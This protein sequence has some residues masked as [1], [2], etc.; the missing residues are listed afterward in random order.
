MLKKG[1]SSTFAAADAADAELRQRRGAGAAAAGGAPATAG[2]P[3]AARPSAS[4]GFPMWVLLL[5]AVLMFL[6]GHL[7]AA[8]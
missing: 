4:A 1:G 2:T 6:L 5:V 7:S 8:K 3:L